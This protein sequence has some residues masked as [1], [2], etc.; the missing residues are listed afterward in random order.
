MTK[1]NSASKSKSIDELKKE[2]S[3]MHKQFDSINMEKTLSTNETV[4]TE[5]LTPKVPNKV[6]LEKV[7]N[8]KEAKVVKNIEPAQKEI[9]EISKA[10]V[11]EP[12]K[13]DVKLHKV[14]NEN[15]ESYLTIKEKL[16]KIK[17]DIAE[18]ENSST[19]SK[20]VEVVEEKVVSKKTTLTKKPIE[21]PKKIENKKI[22]ELNNESKKILNQNNDTNKTQTIVILIMVIVILAAIFLFFFR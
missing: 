13:N 7:D 1:E 16:E 21:N 6:I 10:K 4:N 2:L 22:T 14:P 12:K 18:K 15:K 11:S 5:K 8:E 19:S 17:M 3:Q 20:I 9:T